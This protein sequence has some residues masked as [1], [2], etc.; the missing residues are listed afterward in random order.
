MKLSGC[1]NEFDPSPTPSDISDLVQALQ[2][3][4][5][6][7]FSSFGKRVMFGSDWPVC[8]V[9]GP[10]AELSWGV[11]YQVVEKVLE[12]KANDVDAADVWWRAGC[13]AY[14]IESLGGEGV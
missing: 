7:V 6:Y 4:L 8:N 13:K 2:P 12:G 9:G 14:G 5:D 1:F 11:W 3:Y 10:K